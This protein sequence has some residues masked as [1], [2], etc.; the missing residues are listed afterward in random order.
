MEA[1]S[2][3]TWLVIG[4]T[5]FAMLVA[6]F[7]LLIM[8]L[9]QKKRRK[10][11]KEKDD[12]Q[13]AFKE[14]ILRAHLE[15]REQTLKYVSEEIHDNIGQTLSLAKLNLNTYNYTGEGQEE[16]LVST[17]DLVSK[18]I[19]DLRSLSRTLHTDATLSQGL[20]PAVEGELA[21]LSRSG[22]YKTHL[23][24]RGTP[25]KMDG[26]K[27]LMLFRMVQESIT[28]IIKHAGATDVDITL[29]YQPR[30]FRLCI[31]DNGC[32]FEAPLS[33]S[34]GS[35]AG[36]RNMHNRSLMIGG[37]LQITSGAKGGTAIEISLP[38]TES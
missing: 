30:H 1:L 38:I 10:L 26:K 9:H 17:K 3:E 13:E 37:T 6:S 16:K 25:V 12:L 23:N 28:N 20:V 34:E 35:G 7:I 18:A 32:G 29:L 22:I 11:R 27:E 14:E 2:E 21:L 15:I 36:L 5:L 31:T 4:S 19:Q 8:Y 33:I 24:V